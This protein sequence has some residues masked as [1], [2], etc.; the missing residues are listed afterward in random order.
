MNKDGLDII[1]DLFI[2]RKAYVATIGNIGAIISGVLIYFSIWT[3]IEMVLFASNPVIKNF[4]PEDNLDVAQNM[5]N[6]QAMLYASLALTI[7]VSAGILISSLGLL[8]Y[9]NW[10]RKVFL[11]LCWF[12]ILLGLALILFFIASS[13]QMLNQ[14]EPVASVPE[15]ESITKY[16]AFML[17]VK[18]A[19][20]A[21]FLVVVIFALFRISM[22]FRREEYKRLFY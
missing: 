17:R 4:N 21:I 10:A 8:K 7:I 15:F 13:S 6:A 2:K 3:A 20:Y 9:K 12:F 1:D 14:I 11:L 18:Y 16:M 22:R 19:S 5:A